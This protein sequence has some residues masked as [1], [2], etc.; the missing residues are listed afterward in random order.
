MRIALVTDAWLPQVNGV[1]TTLG[2]VV[3]QLEAMGDEILVINP[4]LFRTYPL[5]R[6]PEIRL[7]WLPGRKMR[8]ML[9]EFNPQAIHIATEGPLGIAARLHC[10]L[11]NIP[12]NTSYHTQFPQYLEKYAWIPAS[13]TYRVMRWFHGRA[14]ATL[15]PTA[16]VR[17]ELEAR[18]F[19]NVRVW[20]RGVDADLF[21]PGDKDFLPGDRPISLYVGRVATEKNIEA[22]LEADVP[23]TKYIVGDGPARP[24]LQR[25]YPNA[26]FVGV[27]KGEE[28][29]KHYAAADVFVFP[30][31]TDTFGVVMLEAMAC[32]VPVAAY[33]V[34]GPIDVVA[35]GVSGVLH[36][37]LATAIRGA[38]KVDPASCLK[39]AQG[40]SWKRCA[41][42]FREALKPDRSRE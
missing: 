21:K 19:A 10:G 36:D 18:G 29:A 17:E 35:P 20:T 1:V 2:H 33:P 22:F 25:K 16:H 11:R 6:Y 5:P 26:R 7:A 14:N 23:G 13:W 3:R 24:G 37:D 9:R 12:F 38:L 42:M 34:T 31:R 4:Q 41:E 40:F 15:V 30:S 27:K 28:L 39:Y 32:G 8:R